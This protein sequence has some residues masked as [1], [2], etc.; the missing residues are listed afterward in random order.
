MLILCICIPF[1]QSLS[2]EITSSELVTITATSPI[3]LYFA[4]GGD[5]HLPIPCTRSKNILGETSTLS[6][7]MTEDDILVF[8]HV[9]FTEEIVYKT[10]SKGYAVVATWNLGKGTIHFDVRAL[11]LPDVNIT[12]DSP[13]PLVYSDD[14]GTHILPGII[15]HTFDL[16][17]AVCDGRYA[18]W[19]CW[20]RWDECV[21][22]EDYIIEYKGVVNKTINFNGYRGAVRIDFTTC[23][24]TM[25]V[26]ITDYLPVLYLIHGDMMSVKT[27]QS[28]KAKLLPLF[29]TTL[30][31]R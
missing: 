24:Y 31:I 2:P 15:V 16:G 7:G 23:P 9:D 13:I 3:P 20:E 27:K 17:F 25:H 28:K 22:Y 4:A 30:I 14:G 1:S 5:A 10:T 21:I 26:L 12:I 11:R 8:Y 6:T 29:R 19:K 18:D